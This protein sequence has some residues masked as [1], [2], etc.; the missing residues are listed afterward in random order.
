ME[1][2]ESDG[3]VSAENSRTCGRS[4]RQGCGAAQ[5]LGQPGP[6]VSW[7]KSP[8]QSDSQAGRS[9]YRL[10]PVWPTPTA[11]VQQDVVRFWLAES[12]LPSLASAQARAPEL[13]VVARD[14]NGQIAGVST[15]VRVFVSQLGFECF[16]YRTFVGRAHRARG[17]LSTGVFWSLL[18]TSYGVLNERFRHGRDPGVLGIYAEIENASLMRVCEEAVWQD[19]GMNAVY[20]GRTPDGRHVRVWYFDSA[21]VS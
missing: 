14:P 16:Y 5:S 7:A 18:R 15:A 2:R 17:L 13:L 8:R 10:E 19:Q 4:I 21:R 12:A 3:I 6:G 20:I 1:S 9:D 11:D